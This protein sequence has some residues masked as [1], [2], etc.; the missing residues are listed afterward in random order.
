MSEAK[1][2][3]VNCGQTYAEDE[4]YKCS[5]CGKYTCPKC[6]GDIATTQEYDDAMQEMRY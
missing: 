3:C 4:P 1:Y 6:G 2:I 5:D